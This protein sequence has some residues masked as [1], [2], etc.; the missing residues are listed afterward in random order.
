[1]NTNLVAATLAFSLCAASTALAQ[2]PTDPEL[3]RHL[4]TA[5]CAAFNQHDGHQLAKIMADDVDF[6]VVGGLWLKGRSDFERYHT[7]LLSGRFSQVRMDLLQVAVRFLR[8]DTAVVHWSWTVAGDRNPDGSARKRRYGLM[9][10]VAQ[11]RAGTWLVVA[12]QN[13]NSFPGAPPELE[14]ITSPMPIPDQVGPQP[15]NP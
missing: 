11:K 10:M 14:G 2:N 5:F 6:V 3:V 4:P 13:D 8:P 15:P 9:T 7:R 1:M 12:S